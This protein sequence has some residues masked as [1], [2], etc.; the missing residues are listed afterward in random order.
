MKELLFSLLTV[1][2]ITMIFAYRHNLKHFVR[3]MYYG[4]KKYANM[5]AVM[6]GNYEEFVS[7]CFKL[8]NFERQGL[9][10]TAYSHPS[11]NEQKM[12]IDT[13]RSKGWLM[14]F[15]SDIS[16]EMRPV[17]IYPH[18]VKESIYFEVK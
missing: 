15:L 10:I 17:F 5:K 8:I 11:E 2:V 14:K 9:G 13:L 16:P 7:G 18:G 3:E 1:F 4:K 6:Y 12:I